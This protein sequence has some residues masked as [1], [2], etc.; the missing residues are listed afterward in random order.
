MT[1]RLVTALCLL[2]LG[3]CVQQSKPV[4]DKA[5][6]RAVVDRYIASIDSADPNLARQI[7]AERE[8]ISFIH[9]LGHEEGWAA[10]QSNIYV[11]LMGGLFST[12]KLTLERISIKPHGDSAVVEFYWVFNATLRQGGAPATTKGRETQV[13]LRDS[14]GNWK[15][16]HVHYSNMPAGPA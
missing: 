8:D 2:L 13:L 7:W 9:P 16:T 15:L 10:I 11:K 6:I 12:R 3:A 1:G 14:H 4:D 5:A